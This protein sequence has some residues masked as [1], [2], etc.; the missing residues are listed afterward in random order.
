MIEMNET[1][2]PL[3]NF[4]DQTKFLILKIIYS[5]RQQSSPRLRDPRLLLDPESPEHLVQVLQS[6]ARGPDPDPGREQAHPVRARG[7]SLPRRRRLRLQVGLPR[8]A[9]VPDRGP[10]RESATR[11]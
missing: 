1:L 7:P 8:G 9:R 3:I 2:D 5:R 6:E 10:I 4:D 11:G